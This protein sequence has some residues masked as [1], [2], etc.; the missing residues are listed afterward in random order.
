MLV[1]AHVGSGGLA[2]LQLLPATLAGMLYAL[3]VHRLRDSSRAVPGWRQG[4][5]YAGVFAI[6]FALASPLGHL[7][8][9]LFLAHMI[10]HL[11]LADVG[12]LLLVLGLTGPV[13]APVLRVRGLHWLRA[14][15]HP[16]VAVALWTVN[17]G[18]WH[19]PLFHEAALR[20]DLVHAIQHTGFVAGAFG[21]WM[22]L[23]GPLPAPTWFGN[24]AKV[25]YIVLVRMVGAALANVFVFGGVAFYGVYA[26]G[27]A[28]WNISP[29]A[30]QVTA[31]SIMM[32]WESL[33]TLG[34]FCWLFLKTAR[35][36]EERQQLLDLAQRRGV[37][38]ST[39]RAARAVGAGRG[40]ELRAR[41]EREPTAI[42]D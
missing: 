35:E 16:G 17:L 11:L 18:F 31:G 41:L 30:D 29:A 13:I 39:A 21:V 6:I 9:E 32:V 42:R 40:G 37:P 15:G 27:E 5:F 34:L 26:P 7:A 38:L 14:L 24:G 33:L 36:A 20:S 3:R 12:A 4:C 2:P 28:F 10:E 25:A 23:F 8:E 19:I 22:A 1:E